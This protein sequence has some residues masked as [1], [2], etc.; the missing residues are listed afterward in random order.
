[1]T[2]PSPDERRRFPRI[3][4]FQE[5]QSRVVP[6]EDE[7]RVHDISLGGF[8]VES[9]IGFTPG[10]EH[11]FEFTMTDG[12]QAVLRATS[13]H[14]LRINLGDQSP[15]YFAGFAFE[16]IHAEDLQAIEELV[17]ALTGAVMP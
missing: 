11:Q 17:N 14:C 10:T 4:V 13:V 6:L 12:R 5:L 7:F 2:S 15:T 3:R 1:M 16:R 8:A 9:P